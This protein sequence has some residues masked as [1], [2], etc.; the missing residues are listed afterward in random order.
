MLEE[1]GEL[2]GV[3]K[4]DNWAHGLPELTNKGEKAQ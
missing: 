3:W 2:V 1:S 4:E